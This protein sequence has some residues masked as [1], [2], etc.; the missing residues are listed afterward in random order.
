MTKG[1]AVKTLLLPRDI[2][3]SKTA[4]ARHKAREP[5]CDQN[6]EE[7]PVALIAGRFEFAPRIW[8]IT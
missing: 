7:E 5:K 6:R 8:Q 3:L 2:C 4:P 1:F